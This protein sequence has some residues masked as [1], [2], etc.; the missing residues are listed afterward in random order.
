M[1]R[2]VAPRCSMVWM[3]GISMTGSRFGAVRRRSKVVTVSGSRLSR[4]DTYRPGS[5]SR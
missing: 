3:A 4:R 5:R 1:R 2:Y